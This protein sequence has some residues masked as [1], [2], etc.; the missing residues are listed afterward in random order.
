MLR[1]REIAVFYGNKTTI[2]TFEF[3]KGIYHI[4]C[5]GAQGCCSHG[6]R[7]GYVSGYIKFVQS[8][9]LYLYLG[10]EG[11]ER[12]PTVPFNGGGTGQISGGGASD[13]RFTYNEN[14]LDLDSLKS[15]IIVAGGG[16]GGDWTTLHEEYGGDGGGL[17]GHAS[18]FNKGQGGTQTSGGYGI[19]SGKFGQ[20]GSSTDYGYSGHGGGG[21]GYFGGGSSTERDM[22][23]G[24]GGSSF[25]SGH[26]GCNAIDI[27]SKDPT[28]MISTNQ[29]IHYKG[30][31][32]YKTDIIDGNS[33]MPAPGG[34][35]EQGHSGSG[36]IRIWKLEPLTCIQYFPIH[37]FHSFLS[38]ISVFVIL[39]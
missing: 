32:F 7:G 19:N 37:F 20:G 15:R 27:A 12:E 38:F 10:E 26:D 13:V 35:F 22:Y 28:N 23:G 1:E 36:A 16:G 24:G 5:W 4:E 2:E 29:S 9:T 25:I 30:Y 21:G 18:L 33:T 6:G 34:G 31:R 8:T 3:H 11:H 39:S 14:C 17:K